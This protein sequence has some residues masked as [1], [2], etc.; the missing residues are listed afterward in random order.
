MEG[1]HIISGTNDTELEELPVL[2]SGCDGG[3]D[4]AVPENVHECSSLEGRPAECAGVEE[5]DGVVLAGDRGQWRSGGER[6]GESVVSIG[7]AEEGHSVTRVSVW[8][9]EEHGGIQNTANRAGTDPVHVGGVE[10]EEGAVV[11]ALETAVD[12]KVLT[13]V[14]TGEGDLEASLTGIDSGGLVSDD[15]VLDTCLELLGESE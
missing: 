13:L 5:R 7:R 10:T 15:E 14:A 11:I 8:L 6:S 2:E 1:E 4:V 9:E 3:N 12:D